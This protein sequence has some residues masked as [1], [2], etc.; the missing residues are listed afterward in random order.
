MA[1]SLLLVLP[2]SLPAATGDGWQ[3]ESSDFSHNLSRWMAPL[4]R[5]GPTHAMCVARWGPAMG[6]LSITV[7][8]RFQTIFMSARAVEDSII[9]QGQAAHQVWARWVLP[10]P[11]SPAGAP[12]MSR[13]P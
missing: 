13:V 7:N 5:L 11:R 6:S 9:C 3:A 8:D 1:Q 12:R 10:S 4:Q 2:P